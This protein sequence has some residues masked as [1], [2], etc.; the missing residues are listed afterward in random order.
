M[1][2]RY[3]L[4]LVVLCGLLTGCS[5]VGLE[6]QGLMQPPRATGDKQNVYDALEQTVGN[7]NFALKYPRTG[8][9]RSAIIMHPVSDAN[10]EDAIALYQ[11]KNGETSGTY[12]TFLS[13]RNSVWTNIGTY[14]ST[15]SQVDRVAFGDLNGDGRDEVVVGWGNG[16]TSLAELSVYAYDPKDQKIHETTPKDAS[17][18]QFYNE[19]VLFDLDNDGTQDIFTASL[20]TADHPANGKLLSL[21]ANHT[22]EVL[23]SV[24]LERDVIQYSHVSVGKVDAQTNGILLDGTTSSSQLL[25]E[26]IY[27]DASQQVLKAPFTS[28]SMPPDTAP[29]NHPANPTIRKAPVYATLRGDPPLLQFPMLELLPGYPADEQEPDAFLTHWYHYDIRQGVSKQ[30]Q[31]QY[32][33]FTHWYAFTIPQSWLGHVTAQIGEDRQSVTFYQWKKEETASQTGSRG[34]ALLKLQAVPQNAWAA[35]EQDPALSLLLELG[36]TRLYASLPNPANPLSLTPDQLRLQVS[37]FQQ[38]P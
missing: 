11:V 9:Y 27:W 3:L 12:I 24:M 29:S 21:S 1:K 36:D 18:R 31:V 22:L 15:S 17:M 20:G 38:N 2:I 37:P 34:D 19:F 35:S 10:S 28:A 33:N 5:V 32:I 25:T 23:S 16:V 7:Q 6:P 30:E 26:L 8:D 13:K 14:Q 4:V